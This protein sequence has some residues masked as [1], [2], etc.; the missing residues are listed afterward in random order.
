MR[1]F[2][3][4]SLARLATCHLKLQT[5][6]KCVLNEADCIIICGYRNERDQNEAFDKGH[7]RVKFPF[8]NHNTYPSRAV[9]VMP[10]PLDWDDHKRTEAFAKVVKQQAECL[11]IKIRWG[12]DWTGGFV[13]RPHW[14]LDKEEV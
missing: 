1:K 14:E 11:G 5:L 4:I 6:F 9:D 3:E 2:S 13:D 8:G 12:G 7:S 10:Y